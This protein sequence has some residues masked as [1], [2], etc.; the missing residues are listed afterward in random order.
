MLAHAQKQAAQVTQE[1]VLN[2]PRASGAHDKFAGELLT[3][4]APR[5]GCVC[6]HTFIHKGVSPTP[7][8]SVQTLKQI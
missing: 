7:A 5:R 6:A 4:D 2:Q 1:E 8:M 3:D